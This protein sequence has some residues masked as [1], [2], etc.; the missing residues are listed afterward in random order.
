MIPD[1]D[2]R[3]GS[4]SRDIV[5]EVEGR[6]EW[7]EHIVSVLVL[8]HDL[9]RAP[10]GVVA[11]APTQNLFES[12]VA[13]NLGREPS[14]ASVVESRSVAEG[15]RHSCSLTLSLGAEDAAQAR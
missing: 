11:E 6:R 3:H 13:S 1:G 12:R 5:G 2:R 9:L 10:D 14:E 8:R 7:H 15:Y 4:V